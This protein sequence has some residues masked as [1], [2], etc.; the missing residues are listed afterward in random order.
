MSNFL[1]DT[2]FCVVVQTM[3]STLQVVIRDNVS[4][5]QLARLKTLFLH[6]T[7]VKDPSMRKL[8]QG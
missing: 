4:A 2:F 5:D 3:H 6:E 7:A 8:T 1:P